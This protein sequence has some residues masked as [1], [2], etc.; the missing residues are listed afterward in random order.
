MSSEI[1]KSPPEALFEL[2]VDAWTRPFWDAAARHRL[3]APQCAQCGRFRMPPTPF[4]PHCLSQELHWPE[5]SGR[6]AVYSYTIVQRALIPEMESSLPYVP[7]LV[8]LPD[9]DNVRLITNIVGVPL[10]RIAIGAAV[11]VVWDDRSDGV[12]VPRFTLA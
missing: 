3:V 6:A 2:N 10:D 4:C 7:A 12:T 9:A 5:L 1:A 8:E 11:R